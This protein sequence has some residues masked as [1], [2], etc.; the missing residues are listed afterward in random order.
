MNTLRN[1]FDWL[2][3][4]PSELLW[5]ILPAL[6]VFIFALVKILQIVSERK[7]DTNTIIELVEYQNLAISENHTVKERTTNYINKL[8]SEKNAV[9]FLL[10]K[11]VLSHYDFSNILSHYSN[12]EYLKVKQSLPEHK[13]RGKL[14]TWILAP[15]M[16][17][18]ILFGLAVSLAYHTELFNNFTSSNVLRSLIIPAIIIVFFLSATII[19]I[20]YNISVSKYKAR[21]IEELQSTVDEFFSPLNQCF[22]DFAL[23]LLAGLY[24]HQEDKAIIKR[25]IHKEGLQ[26]RQGFY[27]ILNGVQISEEELDTITV[28]TGTESTVQIASPEEIQVSKTLE[29]E[30]IENEIA[31]DI[32]TERTDDTPQD[33]N[34]IF[35]KFEESGN[36][37]AVAP[38][39]QEQS[40]SATVTESQEKLQEISVQTPEQKPEIPDI[41]EQ[42]IAYKPRPMAYVA[43]KFNP[44][45]KQPSIAPMVLEKSNSEQAQV[46]EELIEKPWIA[47]PKPLA[48]PLFVDENPIELV[49][50][51]ITQEKEPVVR[52]QVEVEKEEIMPTVTVKPKVKRMKARVKEE[53]I[54]ETVKIASKK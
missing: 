10:Y 48:D 11:Y 46:I 40:L 36:T 19:I 42:L 51:K 41:V 52:P 8:K 45:H 2:I 50:R 34:D 9:K 16:V 1:I 27:D 25:I 37:T 23:A 12:D 7:R 24:I 38:L 13:G 29:E 53:A 32:K 4:N 39:L 20:L 35:N 44:W 47:Q 3:N 43:P 5:M 21:L 6:A 15:F 22:D 18:F 17:L 33:I 54:I 31:P 30:I 26:Y 14:A 28:N 49:T